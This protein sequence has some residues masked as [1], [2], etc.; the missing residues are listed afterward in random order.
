MIKEEISEWD[1][2]MI[3]MAFSRGLKEIMDM[4]W[5]EYWYDVAGWENYGG[6]KTAL[7]W[8]YK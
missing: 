4:Q 3:N 7:N 5:W 8:T 2:P 6:N 1:E